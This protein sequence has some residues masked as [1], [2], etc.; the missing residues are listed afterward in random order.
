MQAG[1]QIDRARRAAGD[2]EVHRDHRTHAADDAVASLEQPAVERAAADRDDP[3]G[4]GRGVPGAEQGVAHVGG[5][6]AGDHQD[7]GVAGGGDEA[8]AEALQVVDH[9]V[10]RVDFQLAAIA[11]TG[12]DLPDRQ[13]AAQPRARGPVKRLASSSMPASAASGPFMV[14]GPRR[15]LRAMVFSMSSRYRSCPE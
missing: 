4:I 6:R 3:F 12:I 15:R 14:A 9:I 13:A 5:H 10:E 8:Q 11:R 7:I 2:V 1:E